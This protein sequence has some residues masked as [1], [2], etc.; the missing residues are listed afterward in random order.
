[1]Q[2]PGLSSIAKKIA[3]IPQQRTIPAFA[4]ETFQSWFARREP[5]NASGPRVEL[6]PDTF[7]NNFFPETARAAVEV[8]EDAGCFVEVPGGHVCCGRP[9]YDHGF[10][11][12][13]REYLLH[14][15]SVLRPH[16]AAG[17][18]IVAL[19]PSCCTVF[20]DELQGLFPNH[21]EGRK[22]AQQVM[23]L[24]EFLA[25]KAEGY[26]PPQLQRTAVLHGHC[27]HKSVLRMDSERKI[28]AQMNV[29]LRE[30][31]SGCCGM[32]GSFGFEQ[33]KYEVSIACGERVLLPEARKAELSTV[34]ISDGFSCR[35]QI[36]Q[37]TDR[38]A[39]HLAEV[40]AMAGRYGP[41]GPDEVVPEDVFV[42]PH[43]QAV[44]RSMKRAGIAAAAL[45]VGLLAALLWKS[46]P[47]NN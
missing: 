10:L 7:N 31:D 20:R 6:W 8:L 44:A 24:G 11:A 25:K 14:S 26:Q 46:R 27:H 19:E 9:L 3:G 37:Q 42:K 32:A 40:L 16:I 13:A 21:P 34:L 47:K 36:S 18:P 28:L 12:Q 17:T 35:E 2:L 5:R 29:A 45:G 38:H 43:Q 15:I 30:L 1:T 33:E 22:L 39:L 41:Q 4:P 23:T